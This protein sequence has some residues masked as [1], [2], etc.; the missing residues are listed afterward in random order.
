MPPYALVKSRTSVVA[1]RWL[2]QKKRD[3]GQLQ[4]SLRC[5]VV[6]MSNG[7]ISCAVLCKGQGRATGHRG[8]K[9]WATSDGVCCPTAAGHTWH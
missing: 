3:S 7:D 8:L 2:C 4:T 1:K 6:I 9:F 5:I